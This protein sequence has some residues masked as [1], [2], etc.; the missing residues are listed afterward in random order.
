M[1]VAP[2]AVVTITGHDR[3]GGVDGRLY[4]PAG[5]FRDPNG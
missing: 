3:V 2:E 5:D 1:M 4:R